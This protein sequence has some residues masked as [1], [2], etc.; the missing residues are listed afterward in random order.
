MKTRHA[1]TVLVAVI[2]TPFVLGLGTVLVIPVALVL[3]PVVLI[4]AVA[5]IP[6]LFVWSSR[7]ADEAIANEMPAVSAA[8][9]PANAPIAG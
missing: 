6:A 9:I 3:L 7:S 1:L 4:A 5:A 2:A 8:V